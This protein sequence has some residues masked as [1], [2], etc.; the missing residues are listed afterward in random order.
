MNTGIK[1]S[2]EPELIESLL[3]FPCQYPIKIM[4]LSRDGLSEAILGILLR[5]A[6]DFDGTT[7]EKRASHSG[8]YSALTCTIRA[9][10]KAQLNALYA[11]LGS[12]PMVKMVL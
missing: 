6:P 10:S 12:H 8:K 9:V 2:C 1:T 4:A 11:D 3:E 5:H 7:M